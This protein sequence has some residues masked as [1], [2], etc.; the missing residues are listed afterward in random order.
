MTNNPERRPQVAEDRSKIVVLSAL[1][2]TRRDVLTCGEALSIALL[3]A[4]MDGL[5]TCPL[6]HLTEVP[7]SRDMVSALTGTPLPQVLIRVGLVPALDDFPPPTPRRPLND[8]L[9]WQ[10]S[11]AEA[12]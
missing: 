3:E 9:T 5:A 6:T 11:A 4:T 1:D 10:P 8:V 12:P 2:D 7:A